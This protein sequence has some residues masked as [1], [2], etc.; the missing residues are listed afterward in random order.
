MNCENAS[1]KLI[2]ADQNGAKNLLTTWYT[3]RPLHQMMNVD[4]IKTKVSRN[5]LVQI[6][7]D[8]GGIFNIH[9]GVLWRFH[10]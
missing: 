10:R 6:G 4:T 2:M 3:N 8:V 7:H 1:Q 5:T 9:L